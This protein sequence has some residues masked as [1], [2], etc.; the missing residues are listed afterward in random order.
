MIVKVVSSVP[1]THGCASATVYVMVYSPAPIEGSKVLSVTPV[2]VKVPSVLAAG[3]LLS[4]AENHC[5]SVGT[6]SFNI[7]Q[8]FL[9]LPGQLL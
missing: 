1:I 5:I 7:V 3:S 2:P 4:R 9:H 6:Y 8:S